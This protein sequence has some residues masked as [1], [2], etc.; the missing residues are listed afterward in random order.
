MKKL[1]ALILAAVLLLSG[2]GAKTEEQSISRTD[3]CFDTVITI[4][5]FGTEDQALLDK[6]FSLAKVY[7]SLF[8]TTIPSS[9]IARINQSASTPVEVD[10]DTAELLT[11]GKHYFDLTDGRFALTIGALSSLWGLSGAPTDEVFTVP[12]EGAIENALDTVDD[13]MLEISGRTVTLHDPEARLDL[14]GI[15]KGYVAD[16]LKIYLTTHGVTS[17]IINLG[18]NVLTIGGK[19]DDKPFLIGIQEPFSEEGVPIA[20]CYV[21][22]RSLVTSGVYERFREVDGKLY[23]HILDTKTGCPASNS[24]LSVTILS[25]ESV[26]GDALSTA[27]FTMGLD[28]GMAY[29]EELSSVDAIFITDDLQIHTTSGI[30]SSDLVIYE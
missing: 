3:F 20:A 30:N 8:S 9:D 18:G 13:D 16:R 14:G 12:S 1:T 27:V 15:A 24:L 11:I 19:P 17:A 4:T 6:C 28:L 21:K 22:D 25:P 2:C 10:E 29:V 26:D 5:L 23:H 7:E